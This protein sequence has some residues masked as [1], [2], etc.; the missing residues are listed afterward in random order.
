[1][2]QSELTLRTK[3]S[4]GMGDVGFALAGVMLSM[5][6]AVFLTDVA[7]IRPAYAAIVIFIGRT[8]DYVNDPIIGFIADRTNTRWGRYRPYL[9]WSAIPFGVTFALLWWVPPLKTEIGLVV[10]Y[11]AIY[12]VHEAATTFGLIPYVSLTPT[13]SPHYD[14]RTT[15]TS[16][17]MV[18][19]IIG[20]LLAAVVPLAIIGVIDVTKQSMFLYV[21]MGMGVIAATPLFGTFFGTKEKILYDPENKPALLESLKAAA[22][23]RPLVFAIFIYL[24][25]ITGLEVGTSVTLYYLRYSIDIAADADIFIG[26]M[27]IVAIVF[28]PVW[29]KISSI[30]NKTKAFI[31]GGAIMVVTR[32]L[33]MFMAPHTPVMYLYAITVI[34]GIGFAAIQMLPW[35]IIPDTVEY[36]E[37]MTGERRE[38]IFYSLMILLKSIAVSI[39][40]P[41]ILVLMDFYGY[42]ANADVQVK[43]A[44]YTIRFLFGGAPALL[45]LGAMICA[46]FYPLTRE[47]FEEIQAVLKERRA[48]ETS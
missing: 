10:Y 7:G 41:L 23:N 22:K 2:S 48:K 9:L 33:F 35:A 20:T 5:I 12:F 11:A 24:L 46:A 15:L 34:S 42:V 16:F 43:S 6:L 17:R 18:F 1:V 40:L 37:Y 44:D 14:D 39:S 30:L 36:D 32:I 3:I 28:I 29:N 8:W 25:T 26:I 38:G 4:Y 31:I 13:L 45:F 19:S 21:G 47:K 27:F